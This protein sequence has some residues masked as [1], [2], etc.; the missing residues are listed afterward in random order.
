MG[1]IVKVYEDN[2]FPADIILLSSSKLNGVAYIETSNL[3]GETT[4]KI[5]QVF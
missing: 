4:L 3:D 5:R 2:F 1:E